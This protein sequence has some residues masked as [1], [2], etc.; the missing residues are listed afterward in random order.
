MQPAPHDHETILEV[1]APRVKF[2]RGA[3]AEVGAEAAAM[4]VRRAALFTDPHVARLE[5]TERARRSLR[6]AGVDV[7]EYDGVR[8]E[9]TDASFRDAAAFAAD[10]KVDG[11]V[12]IGG[13]SAIDTA[14]AANLYATYPAPFERY[15]NAPLGE[16]APVPGPLRPHIACPTTSG[17]GSE[18]TGIAIFDFTAH[19][20]KT[21]IA[22]RRLRPVLGIVDPDATRTLPSEVVACSGFDVLAHALESYTAKPYTRRPRP[23]TP[24]ARPLS[25]GA[26]PYSDLACVEALR[27]LGV[28]LVRAVEDAHDD[29][30]REAVMYAATLAGI[31]FGNA[32][33]HVPHGMAY[34]VAGLVHDFV[35]AGYDADHAMVPHG[36]SVIVSAPAVARFTAPTAP[37]HHRRVA[38][39]LG[40]S[41]SLHANDAGDALADALAGLMRATRMPSGLRALGYGDDDVPALVDGAFAQQRLLANAPRAVGRE[42]L[43]ALFTAAAAYW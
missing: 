41:T 5:L 21:G 24:L 2:G 10:A 42:E 23:A 29:E 43:T 18:C 30:A 20:V 9:P 22:S 19:D 11:Y 32:G 12:S 33:V 27:L 3:I 26:N 34:A 40:A 16:G 17:T 1:E 37:D 7:A 6:D 8:I 25:Q 15:V 39:L 38:V 31:G 35:P 4:G 14:K 13:G 36:M 28:H